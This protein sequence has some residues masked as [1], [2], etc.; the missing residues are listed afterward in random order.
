MTLPSSMFSAANSRAVT[1]VVVGHGAGASLLHRQAGLSTVEGLYL[2]LFIDT[3]DQSLVGRIEIKPDHVSYL[4]GEVPIARNLESLYQ[5]RLQSM[6]AP[7]PLN[8]AARQ[9]RRR[10]HAAQAPMGRV[11]G[12][13]VQRHMHHLFD[14]LSRQRLAPGWAGRVFQP[15]LD[16]LGGVATAP[17]ADREHAFAYGRCNRNRL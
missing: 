7:D 16:T 10:G 11:R 13:R 9:P 4:G 8:A 5:V 14:L 17:T 6:R 1:L 12:L 2:A 3:K 15:A